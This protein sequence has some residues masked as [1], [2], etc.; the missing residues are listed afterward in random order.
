MTHQQLVTT[1]EEQMAW[2]A[3]WQSAK[4]ALRRQK[5]KEL[6]AMSDDQARQQVS[7]LLALAGKVES[8]PKRWLTSGLV[9][10]QR[11][12]WGHLVE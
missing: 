11:C 1:P 7:T 2:L 3:Q 12:F 9:A 6:S 8:D 4:F 10:Q 5:I